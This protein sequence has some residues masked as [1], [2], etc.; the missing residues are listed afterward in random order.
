MEQ[1]LPAHHIS[2]MSQGP[3][4][5]PVQGPF[6]SWGISSTAVHLL[7]RERSI[8][9]TNINPTSFQYLESDDF[10]GYEVLMPETSFKPLTERQYEVW[11]KDAGISVEDVKSFHLSANLSPK[12]SHGRIVGER[13]IQP[14]KVYSAY[15]STLEA[16]DSLEYM[17]TELA[18]Q[19]IGALVDAAVD[20]RRIFEVFTGVYLR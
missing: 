4:M 2:L 7:Q 14:V 9:F 11:S 13:Y 17:H 16:I 10:D 19:T 5:T 3:R 15:C 18:G 12:F 8:M 1:G 6:L 20:L